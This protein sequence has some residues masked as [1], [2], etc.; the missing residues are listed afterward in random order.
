[1]QNALYIFLR[2]RWEEDESYLDRVLSY[3]VTSPDGLQLL[4]FPEG[5]N[6]EDGKQVKK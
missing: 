2:R 1:M 3:F 6:F 5:T 4:L